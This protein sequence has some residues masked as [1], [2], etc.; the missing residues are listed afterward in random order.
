M[1]RVEENYY[2]NISKIA[3]SLERIAA[4][5]EKEERRNASAAKVLDD[6]ADIGDR[7]AQRLEEMAMSQ[8]DLAEAVGVTEVSMSRYINGKRVPKGPLCAKIAHAL[9]CS[10][11]WLLGM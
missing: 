5:L 10:V 7:I 1:T 3:R 2:N 8:R 11:E 4:T 6:A 9:G